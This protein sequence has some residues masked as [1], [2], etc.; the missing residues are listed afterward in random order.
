MAMRHTSM[1]TATPNRCW[2]SGLAIAGRAPLL[3][4]VATAAGDRP[5][6]LG[7]HRG[8]TFG[9]FVDGLQAPVGLTC[10]HNSRIYVTDAREG[11]IAYSS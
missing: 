8:T 10:A 2:S 11:T 6:C 4:S 5:H 1:R 3:A 7:G 9:P